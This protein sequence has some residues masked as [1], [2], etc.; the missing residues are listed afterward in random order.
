MARGFGRLTGRG[1]QP[2]GGRGPRER[3]RRRQR[4]RSALRGSAETAPPSS[5]ASVRPAAPACGGA[6][7][8]PRFSQSPRFLPPHT[9]RHCGDLSLLKFFASPLPASTHAAFQP[10]IPEDLL[11]AHSWRRPDK[12]GSLARTL[13]SVPGGVAPGCSSRW[14]VDQGFR[15]LEKAVVEKENDIKN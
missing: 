11:N 10:F 15:G 13:V 7:N 14:T 4:P 5:Q 6:P 8:G 1:L 12:L 3:R 9:G 2:E